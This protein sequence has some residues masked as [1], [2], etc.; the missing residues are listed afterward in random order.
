MQRTRTVLDSTVRCTKAR[1]RLGDWVFPEN[2]RI[3]LSLALVHDSDESFSDAMSF[4]PDRFLGSAAKPKAWI[5][6]GGGVNRCVGAALAT[7]EMDITLRLLLREFRFVPTD[8]PDERPH[9][10]GMPTHRRA[11]REQ[12][13]T[14]APIRRCV[15]PTLLRGRPPRRIVGVAYSPL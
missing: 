5:P 8:A 1:I 7:M 14:G 3:V 13:C 15:L 11:A 10:R 2:T 12:W 9:W 6:F 4:N